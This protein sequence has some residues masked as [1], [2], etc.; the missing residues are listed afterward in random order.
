MYNIIFFLLLFEMFLYGVIGGGAIQTSSSAFQEI[1]VVWRV[2][3][4][5]NSDNF[6]YY[7][8]QQAAL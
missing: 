5:G 1:L 4:L 3:N 2:L 7:F 8:K 6:L